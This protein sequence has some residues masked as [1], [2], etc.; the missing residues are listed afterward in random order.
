MEKRYISVVVIL[1][2]MFFSGMAY[3]QGKNAQGKINVNSATIEELQL[4]PGIGE[5]TAKSIL[6]YRKAN[7]SF[8]SISELVK[9]KGIGEKKYKS[10]QGYVKTDGKSDFEPKKPKNDMG[11]PVS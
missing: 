10:L 7:G 5:S 1:V 6:A 8:K 4:L 9:V 2:V 11:K 3:G